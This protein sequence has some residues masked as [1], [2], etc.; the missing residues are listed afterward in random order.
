MEYPSYQYLN[1]TILELD[2]LFCLFYKIQFPFE[3]RFHYFTPLTIDT[4]INHFIVF[5]L[6]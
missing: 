1:N 3:T 6:T 5:T 2:Y 4:N